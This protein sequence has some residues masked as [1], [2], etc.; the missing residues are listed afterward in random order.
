[1]VV[2]VFIILPVIAQNVEFMFKV[3]IAG[4]R[5]FDNYPL[6][7]KMCDHYLQNKTDVEIV[8]GKAKGADSLGERYA[9]ERGYSI[10][11]FPAKWDDLSQPCIIKTNRNGKEYNALAGHIRNSQM[12]N[13]GDSLIV[14]W[15]GKSKGTKDMIDK[16]YVH[17]LKVRIIRY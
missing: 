10:K 12:A 6:L 11:E 13:Y 1:M 4:G 14:F 16:A 15:D 9:K 8:S 17:K 3:I 5:D 2:H 7:K